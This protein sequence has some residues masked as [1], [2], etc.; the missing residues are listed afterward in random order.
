MGFLWFNVSENPAGD[1]YYYRMVAFKLNQVIKK[2]Q[3]K[4]NIQIK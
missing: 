2:P 1:I 3:P 4:E